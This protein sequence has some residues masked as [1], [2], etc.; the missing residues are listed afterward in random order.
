MCVC[1]FVGVRERESS[2]CSSIAR[3]PGLKG[4]CPPHRSEERRTG[5]R[6][7]CP[8]LG[9]RPWT[10]LLS[11]AGSTS[12]LQRPRRALGCL[13]GQGPGV[14]CTG[15]HR[16]RQRPLQGLHHAGGTP[17]SGLQPGAARHHQ[18]VRHRRGRQPH[19][20]QHLPQRMGQFAGGAREGRWVSAEPGTE[21]AGPAEG[22]GARPR[23]LPAADRRDHRAWP[24]LA[25]GRGHLGQLHRSCC[26][27]GPCMSTRLRPGARAPG[28][29]GRQS[30]AD[31]S[32]AR[33]LVSCAVDSRSVWVTDSVTV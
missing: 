27:W 21:G 33:G 10:L 14:L 15:R 8:G 31:S 13:V 5:R 18:P 3:P 25:W 30:Q 29:G 6:V 9:R 4:G 2:A 24:S 11:S 12:P 26:S 7:P 22:G 32:T 1:V 28:H 16:H 23:H 20:R 19:G 17:G